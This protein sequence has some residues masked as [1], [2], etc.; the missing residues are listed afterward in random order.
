MTNGQLINEIDSFNF[1]V[2]DLVK[3]IDQVKTLKE[4]C[5]RKLKSISAAVKE[6]KMDVELIEEVKLLILDFENLEYC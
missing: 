5:E 4:E 1:M 6:E 2:D 3:A